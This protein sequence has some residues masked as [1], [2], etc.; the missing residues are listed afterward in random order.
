MNNRTRGAR[1]PRQKFRPRYPRTKC[2]C[3]QCRYQRKK[4]DEGKP[5]CSRCVAKNLICRYSDTSSD[6]IKDIGDTDNT[7]PSLALS[8]ADENQQELQTQNGSR[9]NNRL[10]NDRLVMDSISTF[11]LSPTSSMFLAYYITETSKY[12]SVRDPERNPFVTYLLPFAFKYDIVLHAILALGGSHMALK[13]KSSDIAAQAWKYYGNVLQMLRKEISRGP[14]DT[15][16]SLQVLLVLLL[17]IATEVG[18]FRDSCSR[19][20]HHFFQSYGYF[21]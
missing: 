10:P 20:N 9:N 21:F 11:S 12:L 17:L 14:K 5:R 19:I 3:L 15:V 4:C 2:G 1:F 16:H 18:S 13:H 6:D 8:A 7:A